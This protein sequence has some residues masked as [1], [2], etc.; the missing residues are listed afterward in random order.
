MWHLAYAISYRDCE[1]L[2]AK[3][4]SLSITAPSIGRSCTIPTTGRG[5]QAKGEMRRWALENGQDRAWCFFTIAITNNGTPCLVNI[6]QS[7]ATTAD[8]RQV[9]RHS[10]QADALPAVA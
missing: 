8:L 6:D 1:E 7:G 5:L 9:C 3:R 4:G 10:F 2:M